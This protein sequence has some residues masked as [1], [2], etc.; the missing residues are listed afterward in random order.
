LPVKFAGN[1]LDNLTLAYARLSPDESGAFR[2][3]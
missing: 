2:P 1:L 3:D